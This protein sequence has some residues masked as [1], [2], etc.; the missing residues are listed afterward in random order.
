[1]RSVE[2][3]IELLAWISSLRV[4]LRA[5]VPTHGVGADVVGT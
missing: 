5:R 1:L 4:A 3:G 2:N